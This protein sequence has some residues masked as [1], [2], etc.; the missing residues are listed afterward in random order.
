[1]ENST[2]INTMFTDATMIDDMLVNLNQKSHTSTLFRDK[3]INQIM[4]VIISAT[5]P[6]ALL[7]GSAGCGKTKIVEELAYRIEN[8]EPSV[9]AQLRG[10]T[11]YSLQLSDLVSGCG[12]VG[13]LEEK[14]NHLLAYLANPQ[15]K[16]ILFLDEVHVLFSGET[17]KKIAQLLKPALSRGTIKVIAATTTQEIRLIDTDPAFN[18]R[19]TRVLVDELTQQQTAKILLDA[20][21]Y[22]A[23][24]YSVDFD[25]DEQTAAM[26]VDIA[27]EFCFVGSHR[28]DNALTLLD[29][30]IGNAIIEEQK[31]MV[32]LT[33]SMVKGTAFKM[34]SGNSEARRFDEKLLRKNLSVIHG[35]DDILDDIVKVIKLH[36][37]HIRPRKNPLTFL[38]AGSSGVGK[39]EVTKILSHSYI[40][41]NPIILNMA[42]YHSPSSINRIIGA[43]AGYA[44]YN[45]ATE[46]PFDA[47]DTNPYQIILLDEFEKCDRSVQRLFMSVFD[48]GVLKTNTG[49]QIDFSK[50]IVIA[51]TNAG[52]TT[53][54]NTMGFNSTIT[55][56]TLSISDL[57][58]HFDIELLNRFNH[59]YT[60]H[61][62]SESTYA[63]I[64]KELYSRELD[65]IKAMKS[66]DISEILDNN[67][68][69]SELNKLISASYEPK[70]GARPAKI[71]VTEFIDE[72]LLL[73]LAG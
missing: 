12:I 16:A 34:I 73:S 44:G 61:E 7:V 3:V 8:N 21:D 53:K 23:A 20:K 62:I 70:L 13:E 26:I 67:L 65:Q 28:P 57:S 64:I 5:K 11:I 17:Y 18:R 30:S 63:E 69:S 29:R 41:E 42:E 32:E 19:F 48:E 46:L 37:L 15:N 38:F 22:F 55:Q 58:D 50:S 52:C 25:M 72:K 49:K 27:D 33:E 60:F 71:A 24:H 9:P 39:T 31:T 10:H 14:L 66:I 2:Y 45:D 35:Q 1:M 43:P 68:G 54:A 36:D 56:N 47:L 59:K 6:N 4:S 40:R 51:T